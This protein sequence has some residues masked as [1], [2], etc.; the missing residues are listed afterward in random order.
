MRFEINKFQFIE[1]FFSFDNAIVR[2][3]RKP[4]L[5]KTVGFIPNTAANK[6]TE[7]NIIVMNWLYKRYR[8]I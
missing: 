3:I 8:I 1:Q 6:N 5:H 7:S 2:F 4:V